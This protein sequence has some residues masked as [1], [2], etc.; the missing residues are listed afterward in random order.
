MTIKRAAWTDELAWQYGMARSYLED[1]RTEDM[2]QGSGA[3]REP[4]MILNRPQ[5]IPATGERLPV[6][7][8]DI[9]EHPLRSQSEDSRTLAAAG[10]EAIEV[11]VPWAMLGFSDPSSRRLTVPRADGTVAPSCSRTTGAPRSRSMPTTASSW[12]RPI[13]AMAGKPGS[14]SSTPSA[15]SAAGRTSPTFL[16]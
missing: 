2:K 4:Q 9:G 6:E 1:V 8:M 5:R 14:R 12:P 7:L 3:W 10:E 13:R 16:R 11:R 15:E